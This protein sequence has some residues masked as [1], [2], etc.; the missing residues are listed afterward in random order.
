MYTL[1][2]WFCWY[3]VG[4]TPLNYYLSEKKMNAFFFRLSIWIYQWE[5]IRNV[6]TNMYHLLFFDGTSLI[7][8]RERE[9]LHFSLFKFPYM[10]NHIWLWRQFK[11]KSVFSLRFVDLKAR[12][13]RGKKLSHCVREMW[14][15]IFGL[16]SMKESALWVQTEIQFVCCEYANWIIIH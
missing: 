7:C 12:N 14:F 16:V 10:R 8:Y 13:E 2:Y 4:Q 6:N 9:Q 5:V 1:L 15:N 11:R 3:A